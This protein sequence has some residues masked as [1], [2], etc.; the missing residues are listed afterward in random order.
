MLKIHLAL[1]LNGF[2][3]IKHF[4]KKRKNIFIKEKTY[5]IKEMIQSFYIVV[6]SNC[7]KEVMKNNR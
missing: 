6:K 7:Q 4:M 3:Y 1:V 2:F 5:F